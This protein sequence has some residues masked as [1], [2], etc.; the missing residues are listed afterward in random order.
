MPVRD[1]GIVMS[2]E[3][4]GGAPA[5]PESKVISEWKE[6]RVYL[7][8]KCIGS[9]KVIPMFSKAFARS[10]EYFE[11]NE[12]IDKEIEYVSAAH[13]TFCKLKGTM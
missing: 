1:E 12:R 8:K 2:T 3:W 5:Q 11:Y 7:P 13:M 4:I 9:L 6:T 10:I